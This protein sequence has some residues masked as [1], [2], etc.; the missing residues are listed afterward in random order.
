MCSRA[1]WVGRRLQFVASFLALGVVVAACTWLALVTLSGLSALLAAVAGLDGTGAT[2][3]H[4]AVVLVAVGGLVAGGVLADRALG[5]SAVG[6]GALV[7]GV[8][9]LAFAA[10]PGAT[11]TAV[12]ALCGLASVGIL[13]PALVSRARDRGGLRPGTALALVGVGFLLANVVVLSS[14]YRVANWLGLL[15]TSNLLAD[16]IVGVPPRVL[17]Y[18]TFGS[19]RRALAVVGGSFV[20]AA[21]IW[22]AAVSRPSAEQFRAAV[23][24]ESRERSPAWAREQ[25][26][27]VVWLVAACVAWTVAAGL[28]VFSGAVDR[29]GVRPVLGAAVVGSVAGPAGY[30]AAGAGRQP[31]TGTGGVC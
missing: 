8:G 7:A 24:S 16:G 13:L 29:F 10:L 3:G 6:V 11:T 27:L 17:V 22:F 9:A 2:L 1:V 5:E 14:W 26:A 25:S 28:L 21:T 20:A 23:A 30:S 18:E 31:A 12:V 15:A 4:A 19:W